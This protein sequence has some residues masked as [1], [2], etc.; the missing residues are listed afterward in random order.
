MHGEDL[1]TYCK[2]YNLYRSW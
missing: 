1:L 2:N